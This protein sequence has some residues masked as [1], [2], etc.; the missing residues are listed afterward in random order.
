MRVVQERGFSDG[1]KKYRTWI[2][3]DELQ[4]KQK[5]KKMKHSGSTIRLPTKEDIPRETVILRKA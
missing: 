4:D 3:S 5:L 1:K 2:K